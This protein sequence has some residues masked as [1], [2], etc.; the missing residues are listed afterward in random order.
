M[1]L[2]VAISLQR[3]VRFIKSIKNVFCFSRKRNKA[4]IIL[5]LLLLLLIYQHQTNENIQHEKLKIHLL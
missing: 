5:L 1:L 3:T 2:L 4:K